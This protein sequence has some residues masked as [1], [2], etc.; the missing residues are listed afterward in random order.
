MSVSAVS[1]TI[2]NMP[3][4]NRSTAMRSESG[5]PVS[6]RSVSRKVVAIALLLAVYAA[7][8][9]SLARSTEI[10][11]D[12]EQN[13]TV[14]GQS[15]SLR[16][17]VVDLCTVARIDLLGF[18]ATD[19]TVSVDYDTMPMDRLLSR[20]LREE[21]YVVGL[22]GDENGVRIAWLRVMGPEISVAALKFDGEL[23]TSHFGIAQ[24]V[25][26]T[27]WAD[28]DETARAK[29]TDEIVQK[30]AENPEVLD[31]FL[32]I[33]PGLML[34]EIG[35]QPHAIDLLQR[36][37]QAAEDNSQKFKIMGLVQGIRSRQGLNERT[38]K[39][40]EVLKALQLPDEE[41]AAQ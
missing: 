39:P 9:V 15:E 26:E 23:P 3:T 21:S 24:A 16:D 4:H 6:R 1:L 28:E 38:F 22:K 36:L 11:V 14:H 19:R 25:L 27:A 13:I 5:R 29:A 31:T 30:V 10:A 41:D 40:F 32:A 34:E 37:S 8:P 12:D 20:L 18:A 33:S 2:A 17:V 7:V 35:D